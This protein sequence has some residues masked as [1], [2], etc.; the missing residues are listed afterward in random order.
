MTQLD[1]S[2]VS[3]NTLF[4]RNRSRR[5]LACSK[6][7]ELAESLKTINSVHLVTLMG[8]GFICYPAATPGAGQVQAWGAS[9]SVTNRI[10]TDFA[11]VVQ[12]SSGNSIVL[13][14][15]PDGTVLGRTVYD[16]T[17][18]TLPGEATNIISL[19]AS[20]LWYEQSGYSLALKAGGTVISLGYHCTWTPSGRD[21]DVPVPAGLSN[22]IA[23]APGLNHALALIKTG[24]V[25]AWG[26]DYYGETKVPSGLT[27]VIAIAAG[28][29]Y[30]LAL[31]ADGRIVAWGGYYSGVTNLPSNLTNVVAITA[32]Y[33]RA[34]ALKGDGTVIAWGINAVGETNSPS[35][36]SNIVAISAA[37]IYGLA[38]RRDGT[39]SGWGYNN[40]HNLDIPPG[41]TNVTGIS[42]GSFSLALVGDGPPFFT[43]VL[44]DLT[45]NYGATV[46]LRIDATGAGPLSYQWRLNGADLPGGTNPVIELTGLRAT[47]AGR[48]AITVTNSLGSASSEMNLVVVP[49]FIT[50][51]PKPQ[52]I[53]RGASVLWSVGAD[54]EPPLS[55]QWRF[56]GA[57]LL[58]ATDQTLRLTN[59]QSTEAGIYSVI[60]S[61]PF[62][63]LPSSNATLHIGEVAAWGSNKSGQ[64]SLPPGLTNLVAVSAGGAHNLA[65]SADGT[66]RSWGDNLHGQTNWP[67]GLVDVI[68]IAAGGF[69]SLALRSDGT[70]LS[71]GDNSY[72]QTDVPP[73]LADVV[74]IAAGMHHSLALRADGTVL[75]WGR[76]FSGQI[77]IPQGLTNV[78][79]I[80]AGFYHNLALKD[81]GTVVAWGENSN[82]ETNVPVGLAGVVAISAG[83]T[84]SAAL[85]DQGALTLWGNNSSGQTRVPPDL[86][87]PTQISVG[88]SH[89]L[90]LTPE[91]RVVAWGSNV[92]GETNVPPD[93]AN[94]ASIASGASHNLA[95]LADPVPLLHTTFSGPDWV[96]NRFSV[97]LPTR[98]GKVY[99][100]EY[101]NALAD[102]DWIPLPLV[103]GNGKGL[104][105]TDTAPAGPSRF[106][107]VRE[108]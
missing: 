72:G 96:S 61:N 84:D 38:L 47:Q 28:D 37:E 55:Y 14:L 71:W 92:S 106:Y 12:I 40:Y 98:S 78:V 30:S 88:G 31:K 48:Y 103:P 51:Q 10:L 60:V 35:A 99:R 54:G 16:N 100:L 95:L 9:N 81:D 65:L 104:I 64:T 102:P 83:G 75:A 11:G 105:L 93:L 74:A 27:N 43:S 34:A 82:G 1:S 13:G 66:V 25:V 7:K 23:I 24:Q 49:L 42:A 26:G 67:S 46:R 39:V 62:A 56:N 45:A 70:V 63:V 19:A 18:L 91:N 6:L 20:P 76:N 2:Y 15:R 86:S 50:A 73:G 69:H 94:I 44:P 32:G 4:L 107:R 29:Y 53:Y 59:V 58:N 57:D 101:K 52:S 79:M 90:A 89:M 80:D 108:W 97:R 5:A 36:L 3:T 85:T 22:V 17:P 33:R 41:L 8:I 87:R 77:N 21:Y 68:S